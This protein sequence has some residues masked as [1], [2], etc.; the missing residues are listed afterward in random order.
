MLS[1]RKNEQGQIE[2]VGD[3]ADLRDLRY[4]IDEVIDHEM[5]MTKTYHDFQW[6]AWDQKKDSLQVI[7]RIGQ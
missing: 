1:I 4:Q 2:I 6:N 5:F 7:V 3:K